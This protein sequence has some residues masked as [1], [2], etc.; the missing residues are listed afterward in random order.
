MLLGSTFENWRK[1]SNLWSGNHLGSPSNPE[2]RRLFFFHLLENFKMS[3]KELDFSSQSVWQRPDG[4]G[5]QQSCPPLSF[6]SCALWVPHWAL[7]SFP[8]LPFVNLGS[9]S[10]ALTAPPL[11]SHYPSHPNV[12]SSTFSLPS[13][14]PLCDHIL[15]LPSGLQA[16]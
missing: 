15:S 3:L 2:E 16:Q 10:I 5:Q 4:S 6:L 7:F 11:P 8:P 9:L 14:L 12:S 13:H 1:T